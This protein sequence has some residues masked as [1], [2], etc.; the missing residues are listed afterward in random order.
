MINR[1]NSESLNERNFLELLQHQANDNELINCFFI[2][3]EKGITYTSHSI[4]EDLL[5][6]IG[7]NMTDIIIAEIK[8]AGFL[9]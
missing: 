3:K 2:N 8:F 4:Q 6:V 5:D 1:E 7:K 9:H